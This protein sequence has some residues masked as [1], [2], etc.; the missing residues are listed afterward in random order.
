MGPAAGKL[1]DL[2]TSFSE[3]THIQIK[4]FYA[5]GFAAA[6]CIVQ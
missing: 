6:N 1:G 3:L 2:K 4:D 5:V